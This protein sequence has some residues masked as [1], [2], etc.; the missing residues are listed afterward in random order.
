M[1]D[2]P[3]H[4]GY[5]R[6]LGQRLRALRLQRNET[7]ADLARRAGIS[8]PTLSAL[9]QRG[10]GSL[11]TL[12]RILYALG[13]EAEL[14]ELLLPDPPSP[15]AGLASVASSHS[16]SGP[17]SL[18]SLSNPS[19]PGRSPGVRQRATGRRA[20]RTSSKHGEGSS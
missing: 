1:F 12:A 6:A 11:D 7:Q 5:L 16:R 3:T 19:K 20:R 2:I 8:R 9:E 10:Q 17:D 4:A 14:D 15:A 13:R 18:S